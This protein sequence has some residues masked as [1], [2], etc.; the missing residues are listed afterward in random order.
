MAEFPPVPVFCDPFGLPLVGAT[1]LRHASVPDALAAVA[2]ALDGGERAA[3]AWHV[4]DALGAGAAVADVA[5]TLLA[6]AADRAGALHT[7][8]WLAGCDAVRIAMEG[9]AAAA[10]SPLV[11]AGA[12]LAAELAAQPRVPWGVPGE[13]ANVLRDVAAAPGD[14]GLLAACAARL[15]DL[16]ALL[17]PDL[18]GHLWGRLGAAVA[19]QRPLHPW[20]V[21]CARALADAGP[22]LDAAAAAEDAAKGNVFA[23]AKFRPHLLDAAPD[24]HARAWWK[25][26]EFGV[27][28][29]LLAASLGLAAADRVLRFDPAVDADAGAIEGWPHCAWLL[30]VVSA[31]R[32]LRPMLGGADWLRLATFAAGLVHA[33]RVLDD[34]KRAGRELPEPDQVHATWDHGPEIA[35]IVAH[36]QAGRGERAMAALRSYHL[37]VLPEQ[38]L[39]RQ[40]LEAGCDGLHAAPRHQAL[41]IAI[42]AAA[43]EETNALGQH[44]HRERMLCAALRALAEPW[45]EPRPGTLAFALGDGRRGNTGARWRVAGDERP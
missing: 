33:H 6:W 1:G 43:V 17:G 21:A 41:D 3:I 5:R 42:L 10:R 29:G 40:L 22:R 11:A 2:A 35:R 36:L 16:D 8:G 28:H 34:P 32:R 30:V 37:L 31:V 4:T 13:R 14:L 19:D 26:V 45:A 39:L 7:V 27:P 15:C 18:A 20:T 25:A 44:P 24:V 9:P 12:V 23:E 38:P